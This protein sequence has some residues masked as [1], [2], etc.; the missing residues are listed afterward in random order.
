V[1]LTDIEEF[2]VPDQVITDTEDALR[3]AG[4]KGYEL[5][6]LWSG[7]EQ[8]ERFVFNT[9][10]VPE[11]RSYKL[12]G[13]LCVRVEGEALHRLN[14]WLFEAAETLA[15]QVHAHPSRAYHSDTDDTYPIVTT[16]GGLSI[17]VPNFCRR[18]VFTRGTA[19]YRLGQRGWRRQRRSLVEVA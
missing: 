6:V 18:G 13:G 8:G 14:V 15:A 4:T 11:Q 7:Q 17:V 9:A 19:T 12:K 2:T 10:H 5:F 16:L 3:H 1:S